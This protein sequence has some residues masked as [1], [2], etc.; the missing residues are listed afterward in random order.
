MLI[1]VLV[2][3][4]KPIRKLLIVSLLSIFWPAM[5]SDV[6]LFVASCDVCDKFR[7][8]RDVS[9]SPLHSIK[10]GNRFD[11]VAMDLVGCQ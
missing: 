7:H 2:L 9:R 8:R 6:R 10:V 4:M 11:L 1:L 5:K 3:H